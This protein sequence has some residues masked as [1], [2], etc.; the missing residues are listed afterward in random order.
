MHPVILALNHQIRSEACS[1]L[2]ERNVWE[3]STLAMVADICLDSGG[4]PVS[5]LCRVTL[6]ALEQ[7]PRLK[8]IR[9]WN[10]TVD[11]TWL[12][13][14]EPSEESS[15]MEN[16]LDGEL[17]IVSDALHRLG[18]LLA[19]T[20]RPEITL[21]W[22]DDGIWDWEDRRNLLFGRLLQNSPASATYKVG[23]LPS[24]DEPG[25]I[26]IFGVPDSAVSREMFAHCMGE[27]LGV[28]V[29]W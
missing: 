26:P 23:T 24:N 29:Q 21:S 22:W 19:M 11:T 15:R 10:L 16:F 4:R 7:Y 9:R 3:I 8:S 1:V 25:A 13:F 6:D 27:D 28:K 12:G 17:R 5:R 18:K 14:I 2:D 20:S